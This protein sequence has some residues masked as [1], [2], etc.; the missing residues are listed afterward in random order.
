MS[1]WV[2]AVQMKVFKYS[3]AGD[4]IF[5]F[6]SRLARVAPTMVFLPSFF[7]EKGIF[8]P[9]SISNRIYT[10]IEIGNLVPQ[11]TQSEIGSIGDLNSGPW[12]TTQ[13]T[14][15]TRLHA[16]SYCGFVHFPPNSYNW[17]S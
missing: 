10:A 15:T 2:S 16:L 17:F 9:A 8:Y 7:L 12:G 4:L 3:L 5:T 6:Q 13:V 14:V 1:L 11:T